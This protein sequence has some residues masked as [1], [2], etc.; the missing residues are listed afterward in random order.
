MTR[1]GILALLMAMPLLASCAP[2]PSEPPLFE[3]LTGFE[4]TGDF[5]VIMGTGGSFEDVQALLAQPRA[6]MREV[7]VSSATERSEFLDGLGLESGP[8]AVVTDA[9]GRTYNLVGTEAGIFLFDISSF[10]E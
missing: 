9:D 1:T 2:E 4:P 3:P 7:A 10:Y 8:S 5:V 6:S